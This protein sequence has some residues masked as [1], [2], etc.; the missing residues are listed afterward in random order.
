[1]RR[2]LL[3]TC[4]FGTIVVITGCGGGGGGG[5]GG[6]PYPVPNPYLRVEV[7][8]STPVRQGVVDPLVNLS[9]DTGH[10]WAVADT[11]SADI[12]G[13]GLEDV[14]IAGRMTQP[15]TVAEWGNFRLSMFSWQNGQLVDRTSQWFPNDTNII[16][17]SEPSV[18]FEDFFKTGRKDLFLS[19]GTD[20][21]HYGPT[22]F[23]RNTGNSFDRQT[24]T[25]APIWSHDSAVGDLNGD[26]FKDILIADY[27]TNTTIALN[28]QI[29]SFTVHTQTQS[30][31]TLRGASSVAIGDFLQ[32][33]QGQI[34]ATD[35]WTGNSAATKLYSW[36]L[37]GS[38]Q[39]VFTELSTLPTP[40]FELPKWSSYN[41]NGSHN[42][43]AVTH[44]FNDDAVPDVII[45]SRP[46]F[47]QT[48]LSEIQFLKNNGGGNFADVTDAT[49]V[50]YNHETYSTYK[51]KFIDLN[52]DG[53]TDILVSG[54]DFSGNNTSHQFLLKS[55]DGKYVAAYQN[56]LT[57]FVKQAAE[58]QGADNMGNTVNVI[59]GPGGKL[60]LV[61]AV[62]FMNGNDRQLAVYM[63]ELGT[64]NTTTA[65]SAI[66]LILQKWPYMTVPQA[67]EVLARTTATY[68]RGVGVINEEDM[69]QPV[70]PLSLATM[71]G[72][73]PI[74][75]FLAGIN[76]GDGSVIG[77][78]TLGRAYNMNIGSMNV[79]SFTNAFGFNMAHNDQYNLTS[80]AEYL[81]NGNVNTVNGMRIGTD[82]GGRD[83]SGQ[84]LNKPTQYTVGIPEV[85]RV[86]KFS[87]G[88]QF[89]NLN[90]NPWIAFS[91]S[92]GSVNSSA[93]LDNVVTFRHQGFS[94]Q[95]SLM[96]VGTNITP[97]LIT[98]VNNMTGAWAET[99][100]RFGDIQ[101]EGHLGLYA[102]IKPVVLSGSVEARLP[103]SVD[104]QGNIQY[105]G[106]TLMVQNQP[107]P[108][109]RAMY[110]NMLSKNTQYRFSA[111]TTAASGMNQYRIMHE[112]RWNLN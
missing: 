64:Q 106:R 105:T 56:I 4:L 91:G 11:F 1:M 95:A 84:G 104:N 80:H 82:Y 112:L 72:L 83:P 13:T 109:V 43:R 48:K 101:R 110:T 50:G 62:S 10:K 63:S 47:G 44:D 19:T 46:N 60:Y 23:F 70:G 33:G 57:D 78:D 89:T 34:V 27:G 29:N 24:L 42:V 14:L 100:Y 111:M 88:M 58:M 103:T 2:K 76:L 97:G 52:G 54:S 38:N 66:N 79:K 25:T 28:N 5:G 65:Q 8:Y 96:H 36:S 35:Q 81:V 17:G 98:R 45:F 22:Y 108:Y 20:M 53:K 41:F 21:Q 107:T 51:P 61:T 99:G 15:T 74:S 12:S 75:G 68:F 30:N 59:Q 73:R 31:A 92:W 87:Y 90:T 18:K 71:S 102:G 55:N 86:G 94:A 6:S 49:L 37:D 26:G 77:M 16:L 69:F 9:G 93:I 3:W 39:A 40:R 67:N 32:N 7:P 85:Y